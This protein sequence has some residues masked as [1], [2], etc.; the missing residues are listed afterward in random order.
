MLQQKQMSWFR[1]KHSLLLKIIKNEH[2]MQYRSVSIEYGNASRKYCI[3][4]D[5]G[6]DRQIAAYTNKLRK[7]WP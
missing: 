5:F 6:Q 3:F 2:D 1:I 7:H 4:A